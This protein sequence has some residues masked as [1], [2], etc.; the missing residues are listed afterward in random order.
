[1][2][3][4]RRE[5]QFDP[6]SQSMAPGQ[7]TQQGSSTCSGAGGVR[8]APALKIAGKCPVNRKSRSLH[9]P[10]NFTG[11][12]LSHLAPPCVDTIHWLATRSFQMARN[13]SKLLKGVVI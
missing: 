9:N 10:Q 11:A 8:S 1:M 12:L 6:R 13:Q 4:C 7:E 3:I 2:D 5:G